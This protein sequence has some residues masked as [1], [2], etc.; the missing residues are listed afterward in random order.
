MVCFPGIMYR[1]GAEQKIRRYLIDNNFVQ[2][3]IQMPANLFF[4]VGISVDLM[5]LKRS[6][7]DTAIQFIDASD[8]FIKVGKDN[9]LTEENIQ[10][11]YHWY[12]DRKEE[13]YRSAIVENSKIAEQDYNLSV[14]T[15]V[16]Q[17]DTREHIDIQ[18]VNEE[19][20]KIVA[21]ENELRAQVDAIVADLEG[22]ADE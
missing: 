10:N 14:N 17:K 3:V 8:Q 9:K 7:A 5:I 2:A 1:G 22:G 19:L 21:R 13:Q 15:Y 16:E 11:I 4:G 6:K 12:M 20:R 18:A